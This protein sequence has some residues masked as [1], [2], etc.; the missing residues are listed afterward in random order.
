MRIARIAIAILL[1]GMA[2]FAVAGTAAA[3]APGMP[4]DSIQE[5]PYD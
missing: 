4:Y 2:T 5:M 1:S 3:D